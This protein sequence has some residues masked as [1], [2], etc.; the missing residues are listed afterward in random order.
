MLFT[1]LNANYFQVPFQILIS[2]SVFLIG[3]DKKEHFG[4]K[5]TI[6]VIFQFLL[7]FIWDLVV[8]KVVGENLIWYVGLYAGY[9]LLT[10]FMI[11]F[12]FEMKPLEILFTVAGGYATQHMSFVVAKMILYMI[13][14]PYV[15]YGSLIHLLLTRYLFFVVGA[16]IIYFLIV[17]GNQN[18]RGFAEGDIRIAILAGVILLTA[19]GLSVF[20]SYPDEYKGTIIGEIICPAYSFLCCLLVLYMDYYVLRENNM[21]H[22][23]EMMEQMMHMADTQQ[24]SAKEAIDIINIKCHDLKHQIKALAKMEDAQ[25]RSEYLQEVQN[26]VSIYDATYH[27][28]C[29]PLDYVLRE[30]ALIF[31]ERGVAF[32]CMIEGETISFMTAADI[33]ALMGNALDNALEH[34]LQEAE[35]ER[36][37]SLQISQHDEMILIHLEN[38]CSKELDFRDGLPVTDK[39]DKT[40]HGFGVKSIRYITE[41]YNGELYMA[42]KEGKFCLDILFQTLE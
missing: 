29:K 12:C 20:W 22:E 11:W 9:A 4:T 3:Q 8:E 35:D 21:K 14:V 18:K 42:T 25:T 6:G 27:T 5:I 16:A 40:R 13:G 38:R 15:T 36:I 17:R 41:K 2:E 26:A 33:Y 19:I 39:E 37:I 23:R 28:G 10:Y 34:V 30:K 32:S 7:A 31:N 24:K 1:F